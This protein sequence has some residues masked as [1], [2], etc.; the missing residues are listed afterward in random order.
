MKAVETQIKSKPRPDAFPEF[1]AFF[2]ERLRQHPED[3]EQYLE[4]AAEDFEKDRDTS[5]FLL[6]FRVIAETKEGMTSLAPKT[7]L[8]RQALYKALS[9]DGNPRL[10]TIWSILNALGDSLTIRPIKAK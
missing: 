7:N 6:A 1:N 4:I 3:I 5:A 9:A 8:S 2:I 10:E